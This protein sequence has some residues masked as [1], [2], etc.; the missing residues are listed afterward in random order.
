MESA[1]PPLLTPENPSKTQGRSMEVIRALD[2][3]WVSC[4]A[5]PPL[6]LCSTSF[7]TMHVKMGQQQLHQRPQSEDVCVFYIGKWQPGVF[8]PL[9][10]FLVATEYVERMWSIAQLLKK[11]KKI[12]LWFDRKKI[13]PHICVEENW[14]WAFRYLQLLVDCTIPPTSECL[15]TN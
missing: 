2:I 10:V 6:F 9:G 14:C 1:D 7:P 3:W 8:S 5:P 15:K 13:N 4:T 12:I 11:K